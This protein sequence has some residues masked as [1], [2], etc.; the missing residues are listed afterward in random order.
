MVEVVVVEVVVC[1]G[2]CVGGGGVGGGGYSYVK[3][4]ILFWNFQS[5]QENLTYPVTV[6]A[7]V[8]IEHIQ[9]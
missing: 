2:V 8:I 1:V 9:E 4:G 5:T 3:L 7:L 6:F